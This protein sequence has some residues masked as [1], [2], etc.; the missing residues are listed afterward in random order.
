ML[1]PWQAPGRFSAGHCVPIFGHRH[2]EGY[3]LWQPDASDLQYCHN[4]IRSND[5]MNDEQTI[6]PDS[7]A[8]KTLRNA[9]RLI[10]TN[11]RNAIEDRTQ[12]DAKSIHDFRRRI[13]R[14]RAFLFLV[15]PV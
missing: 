6:R 4:Y 5:H 12:P 7:H 14:W 11:A 15:D 10:L 3:R 8:G 13:K 2:R 9:A 1:L